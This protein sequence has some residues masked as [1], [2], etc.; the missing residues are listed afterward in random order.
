[1]LRFPSHNRQCLWATLTLAH[2]WANVS[3]AVP[4]SGGHLAGPWEQDPHRDTDTG[5]VTGP[6]VASPHVLLLLLLPHERR[7]FRFRPAA[8][9][10]RNVGESARWFYFRIDQRQKRWE[11]RID[12]VKSPES[13]GVVCVVVVDITELVTAAV[14][15]EWVTRATPWKSFTSPPST[16]INA[17]F[18][19]FPPPTAEKARPREDKDRLLK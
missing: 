17:L 9:P 3:C 14:S 2:R 11:A 8:S 16:H 12:S 19:G 18:A 6:R 13:V 15:Y 1:M 4:V 10:T 7:R 5:L